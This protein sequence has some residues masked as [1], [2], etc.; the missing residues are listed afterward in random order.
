MTPLRVLV[1]CQEDPEFLLGGMGMHVRELYRTMARREDVEVDLLTG[2][3]GEGTDDYNG[4]RRHKADKLVCWKPRSPDLAALL[5]ADL[6]M[7][8]TLARLLAEGHRWDVIHVHEWNSMQI[9]RMARDALHVPLVGTMHLCITHLAEIDGGREPAQWDE[10]D[11]YLRQMEGH[12]V[13]DTS[14]FILCSRAYVEIIRRCFYTERPIEVIYNGIDTSQWNPA[15]GDGYRARKQHNLPERPLALLVG[16]IADMKGIRY[17][18]EALEA[19]DPGYCVVLC[20]E[21]NAN[22]DADKESWDVT[23]RLRALE[24]AHPERLRWLG[25]RHGQE[26]RDLYAAAQVALMPSTHEPFGIVALEAMAMGV[27]LIATEVDGLGEVV[28]DPDGREYAMI[29]PPR[30]ADSIVEALQVLRDEA[31]RADLRAL[32]LRRVQDFTWEHAADQTMKV[33]HQAVGG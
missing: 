33:Y 2:G 29:I 3:P 20:G 32:G 18:L 23:K 9:G 17:V 21:V 19:V 22:T 31:L 30:S 14:R 11:L 10:H 12:L 15:A 7:A 27:P 1:I 28:A 16:R 8:R 25:F 6:Q 24:Q 5:T 13:Q 26:L 4:V